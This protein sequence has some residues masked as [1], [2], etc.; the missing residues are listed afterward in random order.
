MVLSW[1]STAGGFRITLR[2][3][4]DGLVVSTLPGWT[5]QTAWKSELLTI[6]NKDNHR[7]LVRRSEGRT[8]P[9]TAIIGAFPYSIL[10]NCG[11]R[12]WPPVTTCE[13][14]CIY[15]LL[16][17]SKKWV[18]ESGLTRRDRGLETP[19]WLEHPDRSSLDGRPMHATNAR[20]LEA[21]GSRPESTDRTH[22]PTNY[23][24]CSGRTA[25]D[26]V[27]GRRRV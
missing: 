11:I 8:V 12:F 10:S 27:V 19:G 14:I 18:E 17:T 13:P 26:P 16:A 3:S 22:E 5:M 21:T 1:I 9:Y 24:G 2:D 20:G 4:R 23:Y 25:V 15:L 7:A 6:L